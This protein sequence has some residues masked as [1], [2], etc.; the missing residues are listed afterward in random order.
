[1][2]V[3][4]IHGCALMFPEEIESADESDGNVAGDN[5]SSSSN[6]TPAPISVFSAPSKRPP[7]LPDGTYATQNVVVETAV[8]LSGSS[9]TSNRAANLRAILVTGD[10]FLG[11]QSF[12]IGLNKSEADI[13]LILISM[14]SLGE[15]F[16]L[17]HP[18]GRGSADG[19]SLCI[20][21]LVSP[22]VVTRT[23]WL[24]VFY[25]NFV[26]ML[27]EKQD[28]ENE[29]LKVNAMA[30]HS[31]PNDLIDLYHLKSR[32]FSCTRRCAIGTLLDNVRPEVYLSHSSLSWTIV[33]VAA[34][35][36]ELE[37]EDKVQTVLKRATEEISKDREIHMNRNRVLQLTDF[38]DPNYSLA[39][40]TSK[41]IKANI[42]VSSTVTG[43]IIGSIVHE[44]ACVL[45]RN[46]VVLNNI[47][48]N[49]MYCI[50]SASCADVVFR[51][52]RA[53]P[54]GKIRTVF[55]GLLDVFMK[56]HVL[57]FVVLIYCPQAVCNLSKIAINNSLQDAYE[58]LDHIVASTILKCLTP[59]VEKQPEGK[60]GGNIRIRSKT[61][62]IGLSL[63]DYEVL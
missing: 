2:L 23:V 45:D 18:I 61:Q 27:K 17:P 8:F 43:V 52:M 13:L 29:D 53:N 63:E 57:Q 11:I 60:L 55:A 59:G 10:F 49:I 47:H 51:N 56:L 26:V 19:I 32:M 21:L 31:Q 42:L 14:L 5:K 1:M 12:A 54:S 15:S 22:D 36:I 25:D 9:A 28:R 33:K 50:S 30:S 7:V 48:I 62:G 4:A 46:V 35:N 38:S 20:R 3:Q 6:K 37:L 40:Q 34:W 39:P 44:T 24:E 41:R 16:V 58:F